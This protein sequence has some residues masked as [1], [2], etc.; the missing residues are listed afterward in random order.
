MAQMMYFGKIPARGDFIRANVPVQ[1]A[2]VLDNWISQGLE[3]L[4]ADPEWKAKYDATSPIDFL[5]T[6]TRSRQAI[7]G[8][9]ISSHDQTERRYPFSVFTVWDNLPA[10]TF[11]QRSPLLLG[12]YWG[13]TSAWATAA[14]SPADPVRTLL[15]IE[16]EGPVAELRPDAYEAIYGDFLE[17]FTSTRLAECL[18]IDERQLRRT[19]LGLAILLNPIRT[20]AGGT[21]YRGFSLPLPE[22]PLYEG[23]TGAFWMELIGTFLGQGD[24]EIALYRYRRGV[25]RT[26]VLNLAG[27]TARTFQALFEGPGAD[28]AIIDLGAAD[29]VDDQAHM[30]YAVQYLHDSLGATTP[31]LRRVTQLFKEIFPQR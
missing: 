9:I 22:D 20:N 19:I 7:A 24:F 5:F 6:R 26:C 29:W 4:V 1:I 12:R 2:A 23:L 16:E 17:L 10:G 3:L 21:M 25:A 11:A 31:S 30:D 27:P 28:D 8:S 14:R 15:E 18:D 13:R